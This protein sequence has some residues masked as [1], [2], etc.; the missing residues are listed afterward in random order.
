MLI[1]HACSANHT[2]TYAYTYNTQ[3]STYKQYIYTS[4]QIVSISQ[5]KLLLLIALLSVALKLI[6]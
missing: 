5:I 3:H 1:T 6:P 4:S 2:K